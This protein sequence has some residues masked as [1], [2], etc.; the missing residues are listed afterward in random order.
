MV[1]CRQAP[2]R[3]LIGKDHHRG[4][5]ESHLKIAILGAKLPRGLEPSR[6]E[7][8]DRVGDRKIVKQRQL[9]ID[10]EPT[11]HE[12]VGFGRS[13]GGDDQLPRP[14]FQRLD[15]RRV[16]RVVGVSSAI[17]GARVDDQRAYRPSSRRTISSALRATGSP[18][19]RATPADRNRRGPAARVVLLIASRMISACERPDSAANRR[20][21]A[22]SRSS[23]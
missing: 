20:N 10:A 4:I 19:P 9:G 17:Q 12:V 1:E 18:L 13:E 14:S 6:V 7:C 2:R 16:I 15:D 3:P 8:L 22:A 21:A 23:R 5:G 11:Q